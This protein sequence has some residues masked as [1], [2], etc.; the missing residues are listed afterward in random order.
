MNCGASRKSF[1][2]IL[3]KEDTEEKGIE[4]LEHSTD[5]ESAGSDTAHSQPSSP[6]QRAGDSTLL[7]CIRRGKM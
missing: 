4:L 7:S 6:A 1:F 3:R 5:H 2:K